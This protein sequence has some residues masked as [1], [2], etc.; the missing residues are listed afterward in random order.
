M[1]LTYSN[2]TES[3]LGALVENLDRARR[4]GASPLDPPWLIVPSASLETW[5]KLGVAR[6]TG[7][8]ANFEVHRL[9]RFVVELVQAERP[10]VELV[11]APRLHGLLLQL[12]HDEPT[13]ADRELVP[14]ARYLSAAG[15]GRDALDQRRF[16]L[17]RQ[18]ALLFD[19]Y[20]LSRPDMLDAWLR[21]VCVCGPE[22][23]DTERWQKRLW[24]ALFGDGGIARV[25]RRSGAGGRSLLPL[26][27]AVAE[28]DPRKLALPPALHV[29]GLSYVAQVFQRVLKALASATHLHVYTLNPCM[30]LW[31]DLERTG[32]TPALRLWGRPGGENMRLLNELSDCDFSPRFV[33][34][35][36]A[37]ATLLSGLQR[38]VL[39]REPERPER[40]GA[41]A[42][43][44]I[45][46][47]ACPGV[48]REVEIIAAEIWKL[49]RAA[50]DAAPLRF[51][52]IAVVVPA[53][54]KET[55]QTHVAAVFR[56]MHDLPHCLVDLPLSAHS[57]VVEAIELI[58]DLPFGEFRRRE[59]LRVATHPA[60]LGRFDEAA[61][62]RDEWVGWCDALGIVHGADHHDHAGT[63]IERDLFNWDQGLKRLALGAW[64]SGGGPTL[65]LRRFELDGEAYLPEEVGQ[66]RVGSSA[67]F[68]LLVRSLIADARFARSA[69]LTL[70]EWVRFLRGL[71][72]SYVHPTDDDDQRALLRCH[73]ALS[74]LEE[75]E[76]GEQRVSYRVAAE[77]ARAALLGLS[78]SRG[79]PLSHGV[80]VAPL[81]P[82]RAIP[83]RAVFLAGLGEGHFPSSD[84]RNPLD[85]RRA[86]RR[87]GD[88]SPRDQDKYLFLEALLCARER[89]YLSYV[90]REPLTG[91]PHAPSSVVVELLQMLDRGYVDRSSLV[92]TFP[93][94]RHACEHTR[95]ASRPAARE[96]QAQ[97]LGVDL[98]RHVDGPADLPPAGAAAVR[99][100]LGLTPP[101]AVPLHTAETLHIP[102]A[103]LRRFLECPLQGA[104]RYLLGMREE[105]DQDLTARE[106]EPFVTARLDVIVALREL[107]VR[108]AALDDQ[109]LEEAFLRLREVGELSGSMPSGLFGQAERP[110]QLAIVRGWRTLYTGLTRGAAAPPRVVRF[111]AAEEGARVDEQYD[112]VGLEVE[113]PGD[114]GVRTVKVH[115]HGRTEALVES[116]V[117]PGGSLVLVQRGRARDAFARNGRDAL[118]GF[119]DQL[120]LSA[121]GR[122]AQAGWHAFIANVDLDEGPQLE[123]VRFGAISADDARAYLRTLLQDLLT[124]THDYCLPCEAVFAHAREPGRELAAIVDELRGKKE[125][126]FSSRFGPVRHGADRDPPDEAS[127]RRIIERRF[128]LF[129]ARRGAP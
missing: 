54:Q 118:R 48:R 21:D 56:E 71:L 62:T 31:E 9:R 38:D 7:I 44:S 124:G 69:T 17:S 57:R 42:D 102:I 16:Q 86:A 19:E 81:L 95:F 26:H 6:T 55:Y 14:V 41:T 68:G 22:H 87:A 101:Q 96:A 23:A 52:E 79:Q 60:V 65:D 72:S 78:S 115:L 15:A 97:A 109:A 88:V 3:L 84:R 121:S 35:T 5:V 108:T 18:V 113:L 106:D 8:A 122:G 63:Y 90:S 125:Y 111:G 128:G 67:S 36:E 2:Q 129:F 89:L 10:S 32:D 110:A 29:F 4:G 73:D 70:S 47:L 107:F 99:E 98:R 34:P 103:A 27:R 43:G 105:D 119:F 104:A 91:E 76:L 114:G 64:M 20:G 51:N 30:E 112:A 11:D 61:P 85:L 123:T 39:K 28:L 45:Q 94:R 1:L 83:F 126:A 33:D 80:V 24:Q 25:A 77:L 40:V 66:S 12:L 93:L 59:L 92:R 50:D 58:L 13:L 37:R 82:M 49:V 74:S 120:V 100:Q 127:A 116:G 75:V 117:D 46:V 53:S